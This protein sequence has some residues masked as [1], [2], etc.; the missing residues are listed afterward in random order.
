MKKK[1]TTL[2]AFLI[3]ACLTYA[4][5]CTTER[6]LSNDIILCQGQSTIITMTSSELGITY[7]LRDGILNVGAPIVATGGAINFNVTPS[8]STTYSVYNVNCNI[9]YIDTCY[10][11]VNPIPNA[12]ATNNSQ[13]IC[14]NTA[15]ATMV[16]SGNVIGTVYNWTRDNTSNV[17]GIATSG[18]GNISG[19]LVNTT[20]LPQTVTFTI[21]PIANG[22]SGTA[23]ITTVTVEAAT[24]AGNVT[25]TP[26]AVLPSLNLF[27]HCH[28]GIGTLYLSNHIGN[29]LRWE[30]ST[31]SGLNW[32][33]IANTTN[34]YNYSGILSSTI[35]RTVI[36]N[37]PF[38]AIQYST[39]SM[40]NVIPNIK[41]SPVTA[42][43]PTICNGDSSILTAESGYATS[44][45]LANGGDFLSANPTGWLVDGCGN[46]LSAGTSNTNPNPWQLSA[47]NGGTYS[48]VT[49]T[50]DKKFV[51]ANGDFK[52][53]LETP[54]FNTFGL[55]TAQLTFNH[56]FKLL[57]GAT[58]KVEISVNGGPY[59]TLLQFIGP[60]NR[61]PSLNFHT[62]PVEIINLSNY[63][64]QPNLRIRFNYRGTVGSSWAIDNIQIPDVPVNL[65][66]QWVDAISGTFI[67]SNSSITV[68]PS[69][70]TTY[71]VTSFLNGCNS[72]GTEGTTLITVFVNP[73]PTAIISQDQI[74]CY[75]GTATFSVNLTGTAPWSLT[76]SNGTT[77][78]TVNNIMSSPYI[79]NIPNII[80]DKTYTISSLS[81][82]F[83]KAIASDFIGQ[84]TV[85]VLDGTPGL[86][87]GLVSNDWFNCMN[88]D[89]GLPSS[90][91]DALIP[92][93]TTVMPIIDPSTSIYAASYGNIASARD[94][95]IQSGTS[96]TMATNS[97]LE[98][99]RN[100]R[101]SGSFIPGQGT[102][103]FVGALAKQIQT[104]NLGIKLSEKFYNLTLNTS[105][106]ALGV[107]VANMFELTVLNNV[108]LTRGDLRLTGEA[109]LIQASTFN[110]STL[111]SGNLLIDQQGT[112]SSYHYN[113]WCSPVSLNGTNYN[114]E[115]VLRDGT[116]SNITPFEPD[117]ISFGYG[118][119]YADGPLTS[120][121][122]ISNRWLYK[123]A[124]SAENYFSW[125]AIQSF[126]NIGIGE[127]FTMKG[128][129]GT[130]AITDQQNYVFKG[131]PNNGSINL[132]IGANQVYLIGNPFPSALDADQFILDNIKDGGNATTNVI[133]GA[134]YFWD[135]FGAQTHYLGQ[136]IGGYATYTLM[137]GVFAVSN[138]PLI[139]NN[140]A[141]GGKKPKQFIPVGQG[142]FVKSKLDAS[143]TT[144]NPNLSTPITGGT[145]SI[146]NS[147]RAFSRESS[148]NSIFIK[149]E[150][151]VYEDF[152]DNRMKIRL[153]IEM[154][155]DIKRQIL[156]GV[157]NN[158]SNYFD[159]GL[160][161]EMLDVQN[162]DGFWILNNAPLIIQAIPNFN[163]D[164]IIPL[165]IKITNATEVKIKIDQ[166]ENISNA[167]DI[168]LFDKETAIYH[169]LRE[170]NVIL[171]LSPNEYTN[172]FSIRF[173]NPK[174]N[175]ET[176]DLNNEVLLYVNNQ[177][178][179]LNIRN[180]LNDTQITEIYLFN[181]LGQLINK[182]NVKEIDQS[183]LE[184]DLLNL[185]SGIHIVKLAT[186]K[187]YWSKKI[188]I[189]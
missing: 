102:V 91:I 131:K 51:I 110:N 19:T 158:A 89:G 44:S 40:I 63:I 137:G 139:N 7:Q 81:D 125:Q 144:N 105:A 3:F 162:D 124:A 15:I 134:L 86:W 78:T 29:V 100:W 119:D 184:Y 85:T 183:N 38:C 118:F 114:I 84:A 45:Y 115:S 176:T 163:Y 92:S 55:T 145:I 36:Q 50:S 31:N 121:I 126:G 48:G 171:T 156:L 167:L 170:A 49:Y 14:S 62:S 57:A 186:N 179:I 164:Q 127:G 75:N 141:T 95:I 60:L 66:T 76:Y 94:L 169:N 103:S 33:T 157:D 17:T 113:Y 155:N 54:V 79:F 181:I 10:V 189:N 96:L 135:H 23:I 147:Q 39:A 5:D 106:I 136:Y 180:N 9:T 28:V 187:G 8:I 69:T 150:N 72:F 82:K 32:T 101:N 142:F 2:I 153:G 26:P 35:F 52:T 151:S 120:P 116:K 140:N 87:T 64:G 165:G 182:W 67:S 117:L 47:T 27:T 188:I 43:P 90:T 98:I 97:N 74:V 71:A 122:R 146:K 154:S 42:S 70:T 138:D 172:R 133:N 20:T 107:S 149:N 178:N 16:L 30:Y 59:T 148:L 88:W 174:I 104:I 1:Y 68:S 160:D 177:N 6:I 12:V 175:N 56:A 93:S 123:Y 77:N 25:V 129:T 24:I 109:Q 143:L 21:T 53:I 34:T 112:K 130:A 185:S 37:G 4:Q 161:A 83:C 61:T 99:S 11:T 58:A 73:R 46:C 128:V 18:S 22:C 152:I 13:T 166:L 159:L 41:P 80:T 173:K 111:G 168:Y 132:T 108:T 65:Q